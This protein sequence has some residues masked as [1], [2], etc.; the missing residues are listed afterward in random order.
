M[1]VGRLE[2]WKAQVWHVIPN[3][4][5][6]FPGLWGTLG[7]RDQGSICGRGRGRGRQAGGLISTW[8]PCELGGPHQT[9]P[10]FRRITAVC[11]WMPWTPL[12]PRHIE[13]HVHSAPAPLPPRLAIFHPIT[14]QL[15]WP[16]PLEHSRE[17]TLKQATLPTSLYYYLLGCSH[18][19]P[20]FPI[21]VCSSRRTATSS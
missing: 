6:A 10:R 11:A 12:E 3:P 5:C 16:W 15:I 2:G 7:P 4:E 21:P 14:P 8:A 18:Q 19:R 1:V 13:L 9:N 20:L 17:S